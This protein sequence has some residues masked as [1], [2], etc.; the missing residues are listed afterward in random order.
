[1]KKLIFTAA[2]FLFTASAFTFDW[3]GSLGNIS[4]FED[5]FSNDGL[6]LNQKN[7]ASVWGQVPFQDT[8]NYFFVQGRFQHEYDADKKDSINALNL[9][10]AQF[11]FYKQNFLFNF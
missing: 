3:G 5:T 11:V 1:M 7:Y 8:K 2:A 10:N 9:D 6:K 4:K